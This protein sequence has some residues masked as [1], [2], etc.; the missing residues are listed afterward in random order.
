MRHEHAGPAPAMDSSAS[1]ELRAPALDD[2]AQAADSVRSGQGD[3]LSPEHWT[4]LQRT[5]GNAAVVQAQLD[6][7]A[8]VR[9]TL[10]RPGR[11]LD[12]AFRAE[13]EDHLNADLSGVRIH[14][15]A[16]AARSAEA[17]EANAYASGDHVVF[18]MGQL[19]TQ[20]SSG[21]NRL[22]HELTHTVQQHQGAVD[23]AV[24]AGGLSISDPADR[25]ERE[26]DDVAKGFT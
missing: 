4:A 5:A 22:V 1:L 18:G 10:A 11:P 14:D 17:V 20:S 7:G 26:A 2:A 13:A 9:D 6:A 8:A 25:F 15:D 3:L 12:P 16:D 21:R 23:G 24:T 19:D